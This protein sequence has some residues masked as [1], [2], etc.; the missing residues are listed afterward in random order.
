MKKLLIFFLFI[1][2]CGCGTVLFKNGK[3]SNKKLVIKLDK[4]SD[5]GK[6]YTKG[7]YSYKPKPGHKLILIDDLVIYNN[8]NS[9]VEVNVRRILLAKGDMGIAPSIVLKSIFQPFAKYVYRIK[10]KD[11]ID[12]DLLYEWPKNSNPDFIIILG[13][14]IIKIPPKP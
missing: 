11:S 1:F 8:S 4:I 10:P 6:S 5:Y 7:S 12:I 3:I 9:V 2:F 14:G 13:V